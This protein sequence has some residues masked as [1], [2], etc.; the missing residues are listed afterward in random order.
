[1]N[2]K[3]ICTLTEGTYKTQLIDILNTIKT[4]VASTIGPAGKNCLLF[5]GIDTPHITKDGV[6]VSEFLTFA[7]PFNEAINQVIKETA[8]KTAKEVGDGTSTSILLA[9]DMCV[10]VLLSDNISK[11]IELL[12]IQV[13]K[14]IDYINKHK[15]VIDK[16]DPKSLDILR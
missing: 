14:I 9:C 8:R 2:A 4:T 3:K 15:A 11:S 1:M 16:L 12:K 10:Q 6:T 5:N 13:A 7:D